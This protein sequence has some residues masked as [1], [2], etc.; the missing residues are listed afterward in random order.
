MTDRNVKNI[1]A[2]V[3]QRLLNAAKQA[4]RPFNELLQYY[5]IERFLYR[6]SKSAYVDRF[7]LK[8]ALTLFVLRTPVTRPTRDI[9]LL[10]KID[11]DL[12][13]IR[14]TIARICEQKVVPDGLL[15]DP[16]SVTTERIAEDADYHGVRAKFRGSLGNAQIA[17]QIDIGFSDVM[18]PGPVAISYPSIL[19]HPRADLQA[20]NCET[21]IAEKFEAMVKLGTLNSRMKD[22]FDVWALSQHFEFDGR[23][24][25][26]AIAK[27]FVRRETP[28][29]TD[30]VCFGADFAATPSKSA[31]WSA[32]LRTGRLTD[33]PT[34]F[35]E[36]VDRVRG[37]LRPVAEKLAAGEAFTGIWSPGGPWRER[38]R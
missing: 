6:L 30:A 21:V 10:G 2:S 32:F 28:I 15:F 19:D 1:A 13:V 34:H 27:T 29:V 37:F 25:A 12:E 7:F 17:M 3:H 16:A 33:T 11:N 24:L 20:Y 31:Q 9:D 35:P 8:G 23:E 22:F 4:S 38:T 5:A 18:T 14:A 36:I 26:E